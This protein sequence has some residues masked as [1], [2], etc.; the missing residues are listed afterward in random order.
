MT[1]EIKGVLL[2]SQRELFKLL[3]PKTRENINEDS[4]DRLEDETRT[5][6]TSTRS[7]RNIS[8]QKTEPCT[9]CENTRYSSVFDFISFENQKFSEDDTVNENTIKRSSRPIRSNT[10][11]IVE[12]TLNSASIAKFGEGEARSFLQSS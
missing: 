8:T 9:S 3:R 4:A 2:E 12:K 1:S 7:L 10:K 5:F 6:Y 11:I